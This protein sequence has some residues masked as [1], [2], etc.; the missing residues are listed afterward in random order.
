MVERNTHLPKEQRIGEWGHSHN[1][2]PTSNSPSSPNCD[3]ARNQGES[4]LPLP[5]HL[6][7]PDHSPVPFPSDDI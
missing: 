7:V 3:Q 5:S 6:S 2:H 1:P 4:S